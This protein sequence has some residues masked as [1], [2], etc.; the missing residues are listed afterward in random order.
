MFRKFTGGLSRRLNRPSGTYSLRR[1]NPT[2]KRWAIL[3]MSLRD[4]TFAPERDFRRALS[5]GGRE[6]SRPAPTAPRVAI[7]G[8]P[9]RGGRL[10]SRWLL[11]LA[12]TGLVGQP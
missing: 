10:Y 1:P 5:L 6:E 3:V 12:R 11:C 8:L 7:S 9:V 2:L 4:K